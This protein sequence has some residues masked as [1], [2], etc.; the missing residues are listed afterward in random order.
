MCVCVCVLQF[1][2]IAGR[3]SLQYNVKLDKGD[4]V[5]KLQVRHE[6]RDL[7]ERLKDIILQLNIKLSSS[8]SVDLFASQSL[9]Q[10]GGKKFSTQTLQKNKV[11]PVFVA[12]I[13]DDKYVVLIVGQNVIDYW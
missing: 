4:Y 3:V 1:V 12:P 6:K 9:A 5:I 11:C 8:V 13:P 10:I 7:L 2:N